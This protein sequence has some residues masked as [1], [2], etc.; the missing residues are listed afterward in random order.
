LLFSS[1]N[2]ISAAVILCAM[3]VL[4]PAQSAR[5]I[6]RIFV[7]TSSIVT[8]NPSRSGQLDAIRDL[9]EFN[10]YLAAA[11]WKKHL[12]VIITTDRSK[13]DFILE[14]VLDH[15]KRLGWKI[16]DSWAAPV[17]PQHVTE[18]DAASVRL[19]TRSGDVVFAYSTDRN[20]SFHGRQTAAESIVKHLKRATL[21]LPDLEEQ[22]ALS[23]P[24]KPSTPS[25]DLPDD[26]TGIKRHVSLWDRI[27]AFP[28]DP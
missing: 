12:R 15:E 17:L 11:V 1:P 8:P 25:P 4:S 13:A 18:H 21:T 3:A 6:P 7:D 22:Q 20:N 28:S 16:F 24:G 5:T 2:A 19:V 26:L 23:P 9:N 27:K 14:G 10:I